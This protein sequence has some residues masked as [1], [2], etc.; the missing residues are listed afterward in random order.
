MFWHTK[1]LLRMFLYVLVVAFLTGNTTRTW[2]G[3][4]GQQKSTAAQIE[5]L[6]DLTRQADSDISVNKAELKD[7]ERRVSSL[8]DL[9]IDSRLSKIETNSDYSI[10]LQIG[11]AIAIT[12]VFIEALARWV[13]ALKK[14]K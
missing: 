10:R 8:E 14:T 11:I 5:K 2:Y 13:G 1:G 7:V 12:V 6:Q 3:V 4:Y 9:K